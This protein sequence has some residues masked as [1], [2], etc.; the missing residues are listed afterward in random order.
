MQHIS[1]EKRVQPRINTLIWDEIM[2]MVHEGL[3]LRVKDP[4]TVGLPA[5]SFRMEIYAGYNDVVIHRVDDF[6]MRDYANFNQVGSDK[7]V[8][9]GSYVVYYIA[10]PGDPV[11]DICFAASEILRKNNGA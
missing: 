3:Y 11:F 6:Y 1:L 2:M 10:R 8:E 9:I 5:E 7:R 4:K